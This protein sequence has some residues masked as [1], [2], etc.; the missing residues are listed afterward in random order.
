[1]H[2]RLRRAGPLTGRAAVRGRRRASPDP[3]Q[4][5]RRRWYSRPSGCARVLRDGV[6]PPN[7]SPGL[8]RRR[9]RHWPRAP[10]GRGR[11]CNMGDRFP[12][13]PVCSPASASGTCRGLIALAHPR[14]LPG[15]AERGSSGGITSSGTGPAAVGQGVAVV[16][17]RFAD[18]RSRAGS[19]DRRFGHAPGEAAGGRDARPDPRL[20]ED[21]T[22]IRIKSARW[23]GV[24]IDVVSIPDSLNRSTSPQRCSAETFTLGASSD[25]AD[26]VLAARHLAARWAAGGQSSRRGRDRGSPSAP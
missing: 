9:A 23:R 1:M 5:R 19:A 17:H 18:V 16:G 7:R 3:R 14:G 8:R 26:K 24:G 12:P 20:G 25:A 11:P 13:R 10:G 2:G 21:G 15:H 6:I 4:G 22:Y